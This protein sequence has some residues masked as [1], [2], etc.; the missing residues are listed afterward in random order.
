MIKTTFFVSCIAFSA[1]AI[2]LQTSSSAL[3]E[4]L[5]AMEVNKDYKSCK[6]T[7][8]RTKA[9]EANLEVLKKVTGP[10]KFTDPAYP[11]TK[12]SLFWKGADD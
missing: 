1:S 5:S 7:S 12:D 2:E 10:A 9:A 3:A 8:D 6:V 11:N 4:I